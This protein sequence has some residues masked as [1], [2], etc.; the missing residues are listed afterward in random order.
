MKLYGKRILRWMILFIV[1]L[2]LV[3]IVLLVGNPNDLE[4]KFSSE[5][6]FAHSMCDVLEF[7]NGLVTLKTCCGNTYAG[8]YE[9]RDG[10]WTWYHQSVFSRDPP[11]FRFE[12]PVRIHVEPHF[13][14]LTLK[15]DDGRTLKLQRRVFTSIPL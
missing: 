4:G 8:D 13:F 1:L 15:F 14:S 2:H 3:Y 9:F 12:E 6:F 11:R 5:K 7:E 10:T